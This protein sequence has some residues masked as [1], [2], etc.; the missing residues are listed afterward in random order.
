[1]RIILEDIQGKRRGPF[2]TGDYAPTHLRYRGQ[3][4]G[5]A[6]KHEVPID[7]EVFVQISYFELD[8]DMLVKEPTPAA[9]EIEQQNLL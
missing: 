6:G 1:M 5:R 9:A 7:A 4:F 2:E 8:D 3:V